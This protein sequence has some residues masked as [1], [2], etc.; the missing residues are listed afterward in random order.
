MSRDGVSGLRG[1]ISTFRCLV[2]YPIYSLCTEPWLPLH[3]LCFFCASSI[4][5]LLCNPA[6]AWIPSRLKIDFNRYPAFQVLT[7]GETVC[8][9][10]ITSITN[11]N[12][13]RW[14]VTL[15]YQGLDHAKNTRYLYQ[16]EVDHDTINASKG[17]S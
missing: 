3:C 13:S 16:K 17:R 11:V 15:T 9:I 5:L 10:G 14:D 7:S 4:S 2:G 8:L 6:I 12:Y 1:V